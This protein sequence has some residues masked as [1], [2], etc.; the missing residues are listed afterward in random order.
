MAL[1]NKGVS[2]AFVQKISEF[3]GGAAGFRGM[4]A[5]SDTSGGFAGGEVTVP[6]SC[7]VKMGTLLEWWVNGRPIYSG[8]VIGR[9]DQGDSYLLTLLGAIRQVWGTTP[10]DGT[11]G[12]I[13]AQNEIKALLGASA[14]ASPFISTSTAYVDALSG[15]T[16]ATPTAFSK[17]NYVNVVEDF[18]KYEGAEWGGFY[19]AP[20][21]SLDDLTTMYFK[22]ADLTTQHYQLDATRLAERPKLQPDMANFANNVRVYYGTGSASKDIA[23]TPDSVARYGTFWKSLDISGAATTSTDADQV[24]AICFNA[25]KVDGIETPG[26]TTELV[27]D[28]GTRLQAITAAQRDI[29]AIQP[30]QNILVTGLTDIARTLDA[31]NSQCF[32]HIKA[33][34]YE[35]VGKVTVS[36]NRGYDPAVL[37][38]R[39]V[40]ATR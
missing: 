7:T 12:A 34:K 35:Q 38:A 3:R 17:S 39:F 22:A 19:P 27:L 15:Y 31:V 8:M 13:T 33:V 26:I 36:L 14:V 21:N 23:G 11:P 9:D 5:Q 37:L 20:G 29:F 1:V 6:K 10:M 28:H 32:F 30:G 24:A 4:A 40:G 16:L 25:L 18:N 2:G